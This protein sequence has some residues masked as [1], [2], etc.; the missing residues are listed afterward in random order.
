MPTAPSPDRLAGLPLPRTPLIGR[1]REIEAVKTLLLR[2]DVQLVT[3][4]GA[5]GSGKT[6]IG[7]QVAAELAEIGGGGVVFVSLASFSDPRWVPAAIAKALGIRERG[8]E[9]LL[10]Q[11]AAFIGHKQ[12]LLVL[13]NFEQVL[14]AATTI[15]GIAAACPRLKVLVTS[16]VVLHLYGEYNFPVTPLALPDVHRV[17]SDAEIESFP[18]VRLFVSRGQAIKHDFAITA[19]NAMAIVEICR[20]VDGL[21]LAIELASARLAIL[22]PEALLAR[23]ERRLPLLSGGARDLP[24][25]QRTMRD[26]ITWSHDVLDAHE[27][28]L[29]RRLSVFTGGFTM[30]AAERVAGDS[31]GHDLTVLEGIAALIDASLLNRVAHGSSEPRYAMLET[32]REYALEQLDASG[33]AETIRRAHAAWCLA[34]A[35]RAGPSHIMRSASLLDRLEEDHDNLRS[36]LEWAEVSGQT[37]LGLRLAGALWIFWYFHGHLG[38]GRRRLERALDA[39]NGTGAPRALRV[40]VLV[41]AGAVAYRQ[42]EVERAIALI[43]ESLAIASEVEDRWG[44]AMALYQLG[45]VATRQGDYE[46]AAVYLEKALPLCVS[47]GDD[48]LGSL[49][50]FQLGLVALGAGDSSLAITRLDQEVDRFRDLGAQLSV[51]VALSNLGLALSALGDIRRAADVHH[52]GLMLNRQLGVFEGV[53]FNIAGLAVIAERSG[54]TEQAARLFAAAETLEQVIG[55]PMSPRHTLPA[56]PVFERSLEAARK[57]LGEAT[58]ASAWSAGRALAAEEAIAEALAVA[59]AASQPEPAVIP[60]RPDPFGLTR[61]EREVLALMAAG[62]TDPEIA[63]ILTIGRRTAETHVSAVLA[64]LGVETRA[65]AAAL[66]VRHGLA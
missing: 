55:A 23:L 44:A 11:I 41:G 59:A 46:H 1:D 18:A 7:L 61:R 10:D 60:V 35:E 64:K 13:D 6:R 8:D 38:E 57:R 65:A 29:F 20:R 9:P 48:V 66:A 33:E 43:G 22:P 39:A 54:A 31:D 42:G 58:F 16:R 40:P 21:P 49:T 15:T 14:P 3:L 5:G 56:R 12:L 27:H 50:R 26:T 28:A 32:I 30:E 63:A 34:L 45:V 19:A 47:E 53:I 2:D 24:A 17:S 52:E 36:A 51:A 62:K 37:V 4:T 25:R